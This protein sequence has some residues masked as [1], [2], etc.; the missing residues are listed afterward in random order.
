MKLKISFLATAL[1]LWAAAQTAPSYY[2]DVDFKSKGDDL[3]KELTAL[4]SKTHT[5]NLSY[6]GELP[7]VLKKSDVDPEKPGNL[8]LIYGSNTTPNDKHQRSRP[9]SGAASW[10]KEHVYAK[11]KGT[12]PLGTSGP[13]SDGHHL[14]P[15]DNGLNSERSNFPFADGN[16]IRAGKSGSGWYPGDEWKGDVARMMMYM[17][18]RYGDRAKP[19]VIGQGPA[20]YSRDIP[21]IFIKWNIEDPVSEFEK[22]RNNVVAAAQG[23]RNPF[24]DNPYLATVLWGG[25][26]AQNTWPDTF[27][28]KT[29][30]DKEAPTVP[31]NLA[32]Q[33]KTASTVV[34]TWTASTDNVGVSEYEIYQN[35][36]YIM[37]SKTT[38]ATITGLS[39]ETEYTFNILAKDRAGNKSAKTGIITIT[40]EKGA[41]DPEPGTTSC[42]TETFELTPNTGSSY[43]DIT[44]SSNNI[45]WTATKVRTDETID[46]AKTITLNRT[47]D[48]SL[49]SS[50]ISG[51]IK[52]LS[53]KTE[54]KY[55]GAA[56]ELD[57]LVNNQLVG[58]IAYSKDVGTFSI[59]AINIAGDVKI[60]I[61]NKKGT[62]RVAITDLTWTCHTLG[63]NEAEKSSKKLN[64]YP[65]PVRNSEFYISGLTENNTTVQVYNMS[66]NL[67]QTFT[68]VKN[69]EKLTLPK[70]PKGIYIVKTS[71][72]T[73]KLIVE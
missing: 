65:N 52:S 32:A 1:S 10:N 69:Q 46:G 72:K 21:D 44:W 17:Y 7:E 29:P 6:S 47:T 25:D 27:D 48:A 54:L 18:V 40:T 20:T 43:K 55:T 23:N 24:I 4:I 8:L 41:V 71:E 36:V 30:D 70:L 28:A 39:P 26:A 63:V 33:S 2:N 3:K 42:G 31:T 12:P 35:G 61:L 51:G 22:Q 62:D 66:G 59:P 5:K 37:S 64:I 73:A 45:T 38:T 11:S 16:G 9:A 58:T 53:L 56:G 14:R 34:L 67:V 60:T 68:N 49:T 50:T 19:T 15:A 13:G 57:V